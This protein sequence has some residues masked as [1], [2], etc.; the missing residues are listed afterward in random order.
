MELRT[1]P[2]VLAAKLATDT[3]L[4]DMRTKNYFQLNATAAR[5]WQALE[6]GLT[7]EQVVDELCAEFDA[8][9][10]TVQAEVRE[11]FEALVERGLARS[12]DP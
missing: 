7:E 10:E 9:R 1:S 4:L 5:A 6:R 8:P 3:V 2:D 12:Q 11:L